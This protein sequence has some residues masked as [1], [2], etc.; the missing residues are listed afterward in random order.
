MSISNFTCLCMVPFNRRYLVLKKFNNNDANL[1]LKTNRKCR[2][3]SECND[4]NAECSENGR[5]VPDNWQ[6]WGKN[7]KEENKDEDGN[8]DSD[9]VDIENDSEKPDDEIPQEDKTTTI[10]EQGNA[11]SISF[12]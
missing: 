4:E 3:V 10:K 1:V 2:N 11:C 9:N 6:G 12:I 7:D 8:N 5:C